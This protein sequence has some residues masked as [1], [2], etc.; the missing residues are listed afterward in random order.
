[1]AEK[2]DNT[3][4]LTV[5]ARVRKAVGVNTQILLADLPK[6]VEKVIQSYEYE[7]FKLKRKLK[8]LERKIKDS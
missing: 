1:M 4:L 8:K 5:I 2:D 6:A 3:F 7:L